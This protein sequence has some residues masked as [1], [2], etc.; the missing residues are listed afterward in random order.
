MSK[1]TWFKK[2]VPE[3]IEI[4]Q[5]YGILFSQDGKILLRV[6]DNKYKLTG[7]KPEPKENIEE[8]LKRECVE[9]INVEIEEIHYLGFFLVEE[10]EIPPYAQVRMIA[11]IK[12]IGKSRP[13]LD[14][15][16]LYKRFLANLE[17][18]KKYLNYEEAGNK[19]IEDA[20]F[21]AKEIYTFDENN[22]EYFI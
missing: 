16:K 9:E 20:C 12:S 1:Y 18:T 19:M 17:N 14:N 10:K 4:K 21:L 22:K 3:N 2:S 7:G 15:G 5:V 8:T 6:E 11:K 13:D